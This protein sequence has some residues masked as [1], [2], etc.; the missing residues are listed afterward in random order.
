[1]VYFIRMVYLRLWLVSIL[2]YCSLTNASGQ[3]TSV[4]AGINVSSIA[5]IHEVSTLIG[6]HVGI[7]G[8]KE[9]SDI[10]SIRHEL[11]FSQQGTK[12]SADE[13]LVNYYLNIPILLNVGLGESFF[14]GVGPQAGIALRGLMKGESDRDVTA[15][16][17]VVDFSVCLGIGYRMSE[18]F[19]AEGRYNAGMTNLSRI[20]E[21]DQRNAVFQ[22]SVGYYF[23]RMNTDSK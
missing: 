9:L 12:V 8:V 23:N 10:L 6:Y 19:F 17:S 7:G 22:G 16:L 4:K 1:M 14:L 15:N 3:G 20:S 13:K 2:V 11:I 5:G 21:S 18:R